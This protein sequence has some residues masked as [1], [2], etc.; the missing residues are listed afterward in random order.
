M[1]E[2]YK[3]NKVL[4]DKLL[5]IIIF[6]LLLY[7]LFN[8]VLTYVFPFIFGYIVS[9]I[10]SPFVNLLVQKFRINRGLASI[11]SIILLLSTIGIIGT[12][13]VSRILREGSD[14]FNNLPQIVNHVENTIQDVN[15]IF[16]NVYEII[17]VGLQQAF[18]SL[19][20]N[21]TDSLASILGY[22]IKNFSTTFISLVPKTVIGVVLSI[23]S[24]Y[25]FSK[26]KEVIS[27]FVLNLIPKNLYNKVYIIK[28][29][30]THALGG[31]FKAQFMLM[32]I[33]ACIC[34]IGLL[35]VGAPYALFLGL[36]IAVIDS[37]PILGSGLFYWPWIVFSIITGNYSQAIGLSIIYIAILLTRQVLE[38]KI[39]GK[40]LGIHPLIM[41]MSL[42]IGL[43]LFGVLG[44]ILG[45]CI[46]VVSK[47]LIDLKKPNN[48]I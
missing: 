36:V 46:T 13:I 12:S 21:V 28:K 6:I 16:D 8:N 42:Y 2:I 34:S 33:V 31:Y 11:I 41:I 39:L 38:P 47:A 9:I 5:L 40:Q 26:D 17:P 1:R 48:S 27:K 23:I 10:I 44:I 32:G 20:N 30:V 18:Y 37:L 14:F 3:A 43:K 24:A 45:P 7:F 19:V 25:F 15:I 35:I 4:I 29:A 22:S